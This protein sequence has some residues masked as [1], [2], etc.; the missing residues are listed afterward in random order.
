MYCINRIN[1][2]SLTKDKTES[3]YS[4]H[5]DIVRNY[6]LLDRFK[7]ME[8][9]SNLFLSAFKKDDNEFFILKKDSKICG[10]LDFGKSADWAGNHRYKLNIAL[11]DSIADKALF[12][13]IS[14]LIKDKLDQHGR[15]ALESYNNELAEIIGKFTSKVE[16]RA[17]Y[18][19]LK[20]EDINISLL[21]KSIKE[22]AS[23]NAD[24]SI[25]YTDI[26]SD[27]YI[28]QYCD[29]FMETA[30]DMP[31][32]R[33]DGYV[34]FTVTPETQRLTNENFKKRNI[35]HN[36]YMIFN[37]NNEMVAKSN[38][39]VNNNDPRFP[40][41]FMIGVKRP[42]RGRSLGKW[43]YASM[44]K[45]LFETVEFE[46]VLVCHNPENIPAINISEWVGYKFNYLQTTHVLYK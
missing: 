7:S 38:V 23:K 11:T 37:S 39:S 46:K 13:P 36:C 16:L 19:T 8:D 30:K 41:Q 35:T 5:K 10:I 31:D 43:L 26:I 4:A 44:Y 20:K 2:D 14:Q 22:Y 6:N 9:Y 28:E 21:D 45:R 34:P 18:Y 1:I 32:A 25:E 33:E 15:L 24:L 42:Y 17:N 3:L 40:Y 27:E 12:D 29:L